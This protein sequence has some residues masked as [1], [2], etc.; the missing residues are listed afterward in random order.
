[1]FVVEGQTARKAVF[2]VRGERSGTVFLDAALRAGAHVVTEGRGGLRD[3][4]RV[5]AKVDLVAERVA[6]GAPKREGAP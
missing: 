4:D 3:G 1:M 2:A 5:D 6:T